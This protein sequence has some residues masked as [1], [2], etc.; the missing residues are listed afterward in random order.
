MKQSRPWKA[1]SR[2]AGQEISRLLWNSKFHCGIYEVRHWILSLAE[3]IQ[4]TQ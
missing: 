3:V 1:N 4:S 2:R